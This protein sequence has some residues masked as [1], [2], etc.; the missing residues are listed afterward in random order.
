MSNLAAFI[1][2]SILSSGFIWINVEIFQ[3]IRSYGGEWV[4]K[5]SSPVLFWFVTLF[6][7]ATFGVL[8]FLAT[9]DNALLVNHLISNTVAF[10]I[11]FILFRLTMWKKQ[12]YCKIA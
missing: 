1:T 8:T 5:F 2:V 7:G 4:K 3:K 6:L 9:V 11:G 12:N 10:G